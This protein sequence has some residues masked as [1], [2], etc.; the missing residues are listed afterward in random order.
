ML[1]IILL[2]WIEAGQYKSYAYCYA[3][4][5]SYP[6]LGNYMYEVT[7]F[8]M[9]FPHIHVHMSKLILWME[10]DLVSL[11]VL[12]QKKLLIASVILICC[13]MS[14]I[15]KINVWVFYSQLFWINSPESQ[16]SYYIHPTLL[17]H[18]NHFHSILS[19]PFMH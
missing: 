2:A 5:Y 11:I 4:T 17:L 15:F 16:A 1:I 8:V 9:E 13:T 10:C 18:H 14:C 7:V 19:C 6:T 12:V 3:Y